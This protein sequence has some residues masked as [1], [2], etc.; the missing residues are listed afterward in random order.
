MQLELVIAQLRALCPSFSGR[1]AGAAEFKPVQEAAALPVPC[2][3]V[4]QGRKQLGTGLVHIPSLL[5]RHVDLEPDVARWISDDLKAEASW[6][7]GISPS[8]NCS[9]R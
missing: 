3:F 1:V 2:A 9:C 6:N 8:S 5:V 4:I 7:S